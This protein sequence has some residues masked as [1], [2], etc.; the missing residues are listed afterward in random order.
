MLLKCKICEF[1]GKSL[2]GH[3]LHKHKLTCKEYD[4]LYGTNLV[5]RVTDSTK[6]EYKIEVKKYQSKSIWQVVYWTERYGLTEEEAKVKIRDYQRINSSKVIPTSESRPLNKDYWKVRKGF[7][8]E[9]AVEQV[10][11]IQAKRSAKS[12]KF[13]GKKHTDESKKAISKYFKNHIS[14]IGAAEW[15]SHFGKFSGF[16]KIERACYAE[17]VSVLDIKM[18]SNVKIGDY[19]VDMIFKNKI[20]EFNGDYWHGNPAIYKSG[21]TLK[22]PQEVITVDS[23]WEKDKRRIEYLTESGYEVLIIWECDWRLE[24]DTVISQV[25][26]FINDTSQN[27]SEDC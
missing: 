24:K 3:L 21:Q 26:S 16:S 15:A 27:N 6:S 10:R 19:I 25:K 1:E 20:I 2:I 23:L 7:T 9:E 14:E 17:L 5:F 4:T 18:E 22:F 13:K 11:L 8:E 12:N